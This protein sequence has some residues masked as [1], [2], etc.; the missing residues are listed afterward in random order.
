MPGQRSSE[1]QYRT[2]QPPADIADSILSNPWTAALMQGDADRPQLYAN[3]LALT[4]IGIGSWAPEPAHAHAGPKPSSQAHPQDQPTPEK[5]VTADFSSSETETASLHSSHEE[6]ECRPDAESDRQATDSCSSEGKDGAGSAGGDMH[7]DDSCDH[8]QGR[9][10]SGGQQ[11]DPVK[12]GDPVLHSKPSAAAG[13]QHA[14]ART[15]SSDKGSSERASSPALPS[16]PN[17]SCGLYADAIPSSSDGANLSPDKGSSNTGRS[18]TG[19]SDTGGSP[20]AS[21][22]N[23][24]RVQPACHTDRAVT[25]TDRHGEQTQGSQQNSAAPNSE[26]SNVKGG[27]Q[28]GFAN[29]IGDFGHLE[30]PRFNKQQG[31]AWQAHMRSQRDQPPESCSNPH[32]VAEVGKHISW[33]SLMCSNDRWGV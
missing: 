30:G 21:C 9:S 26:G 11:Q 17:A 16:E 6:D 18:G 24:P 5:D 8:R 13:S 28:R 22:T 33:T 23:V 19:S 27:R 25:F 10:G 15:S 32:P 7:S 3:S 31:R 2:E 12:P 4:R 29:W 1:G 20:V 14:D